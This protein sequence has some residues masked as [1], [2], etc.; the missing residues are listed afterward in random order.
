MGWVAV[1]CG[2]L[3]TFAPPEMVASRERFRWGM[4]A[5]R[6]MIMTTILQV[7]QSGQSR[8]IVDNCAFTKAV[9][10]RVIECLGSVITSK[11]SLYYHL[12]RVYNLLT[13]N[14]FYVYQVVFLCI[15]WNDD[16]G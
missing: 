12:C 3:G 1:P 4:A 6:S 14:H 11:C 16:A 13:Q 5:M 7:N 9:H 10:R 2:R 8:L 15:T